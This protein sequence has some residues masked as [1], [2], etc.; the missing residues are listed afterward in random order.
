M[1]RCGDVDA[2]ADALIEAPGKF[3]DNTKIAEACLAKIAPFSPDAAASEILNGALS[4][5]NGVP[6]P[7]P[8]LRQG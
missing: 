1:F 8:E 6:S 2:L 7:S 3:K 4:I 5:M